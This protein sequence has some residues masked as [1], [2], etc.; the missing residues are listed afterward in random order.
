M[1]FASAGI[2]SCGLLTASYCG[3]ANLVSNNLGGANGWQVSGSGNV[4]F[5]SGITFLPNTSLSSSSSGS[6]SQTLNTIAGM[7]YEI[8][9]SAFEGQAFLPTSFDFSFGDL[10]CASLGGSL[11]NQSFGAAHGFT[12]SPVVN[13]D[14][15]ITANSSLTTLSFAYCLP[16]EPTGIVLNGLNVQAVPDAFSTAALLSLASTGLFF[17]RRQMNKKS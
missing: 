5:G 9:F 14:Y 4:N 3:H 12:S 2:I 8:S 15:F 11:F 16:S 17:A 1:K 13:G 10:C 7:R 6:I